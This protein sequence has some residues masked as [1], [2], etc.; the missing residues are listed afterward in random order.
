[1]Y[2]SMSVGYMH[3]SGIAR[4]QSICICNVDSYCHIAFMEIIPIYSPNQ[5]CG[6]GPFYK[7]HE[8]SVYNKH[9]NLCPSDK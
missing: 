8:H 1:M 5:Q 9:L 7:I 4:S 6:K 3:K 2:V